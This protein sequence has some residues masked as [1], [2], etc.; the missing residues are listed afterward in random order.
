MIDINKCLD[1][2]NAYIYQYAGDEVV[3]T[4]ETSQE[5]SLLALRFFFACVAQINRREDFYF[6]NFGTVP[7][8]KAGIDCGK[9]TAVEIGDLKRDIA[10]HGDSINTAARIQALCNSFDKKLLISKSL[11]GRLPAE[12]SFQLEAMGSFLLRGKEEAVELYAISE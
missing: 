5:N 2:Y 7:A 12:H 9:V 11:A 4:W 3:L 1:D 10:Y 6:K 8:F